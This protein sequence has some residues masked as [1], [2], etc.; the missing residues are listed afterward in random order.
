[1]S[2][3]LAPIPWIDILLILALIALNGGLAM[4]ELA[5]VSSR[6]A[7]LKAMAKSGSGGAQCALDLA[8]DPGRFLSTV[9]SGITLIAIF[10]GAFS[11]ER[12]GEPTAE[13]MQLLGLD[14]NSAHTVGFGLVIFVTTYASL[15]V[16]EIVPKQIALRSP[17]PIAVIMAR[18]MRWLSVATAPFVWV[19]ERS[20]AL[21]FRL[22]GLD[23]GSKNQVTAEELH[24]VVAEAQTAGVLE[25]DERAMISGIVRLADRPVREVMT[26]RTE[27]DWIDVGA[28]ADE[29]REALLETPHSRIPVTD[30][31]VE[32]IVGVIQTRDVMAALLQG[33][34]IDLKLLCR[35]APVIPD[36]MDAM[37]A[38]AVLRAADVPL[39]L[40]HDEYGHLDGIVTPG[41]ILAA[42]AGTFAHD[43]EWGE[44]PPLVERDDGSWLVSGAA[45]ADLLADRLG[46]NLPEER[47]YSTAAGFA[48]SVLKHLPDTGEKFRHDGWSFEIVDMDGR[49][50]DKLIA[51]RPRKKPAESEAEAVG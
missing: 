1:M 26:P 48:L 29:I 50:I 8:A 6:E 9:Q 44:E 16:G 49:K 40:V 22:F 18:P 3:H 46:V 25:E 24:L 30:G 20:S 15:V 10:V 34:P 12:L 39:A 23:R 38:L 21:I 27:I 36:L 14:A 37:D 7:R 47:D 43:V 45:S 51:S 17:E 11:G 28:S 32:N 31:A 42:L 41:S 35:A 4:S 13:R 5:I 19:L 2:D 33:H